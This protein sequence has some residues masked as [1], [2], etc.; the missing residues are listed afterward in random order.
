MFTVICVKLKPHS[1]IFSSYGN[2]PIVTGASM[3]GLDKGPFKQKDVFMI[4][5]LH[6][7]VTLVI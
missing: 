6:L 1:K 4:S 5:Y 2:V 7:H 3:A